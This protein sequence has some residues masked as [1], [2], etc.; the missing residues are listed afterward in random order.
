MNFQRYVIIFFVVL[1]LIIMIFLG[2]TMSNNKATN[3]PWPPIISSCPDYWTDTP[4]EPPVPVT[5]CTETVQYAECEDVSCPSEAVNGEGAIFNSYE[6]EYITDS[7]GNKIIVTDPSGNGKIATDSISNDEIKCNSADNKPCGL[8]YSNTLI[9]GY[10]LFGY[11]EVCTTSDP[12]SNYIPIPHVPGSRCIGTIGQNNGSF[13]FDANNSTFNLSSNEKP[14]SANCTSCKTATMD[15]TKTDGDTNYI[16]ANGNCEKQ[17]WAQN[18][19]NIS[20]DGITYG[21]GEQNPCWTP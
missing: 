7:S 9:S 3:I 1:L 11:N 17:N 2:V 21:F 8:K 16:G 19:G 12:I 13:K 20:W 14:T 6:Y 10:Q 18:H 4:D 15:F 5:T